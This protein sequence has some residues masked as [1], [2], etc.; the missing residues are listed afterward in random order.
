MLPI[1]YFP[2]HIVLVS[3]SENDN[4][5][6]GMLAILF[7]IYTVTYGIKDVREKWKSRITL[8][9]WLW[10]SKSMAFSFTKIEKT[11]EKQIYLE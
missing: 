6:S 2:L 1:C 9:F 7:Q 10:I 11:T 4:L 5:G 3:S 8:R